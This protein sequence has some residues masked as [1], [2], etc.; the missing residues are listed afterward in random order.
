[1]ASSSNRSGFSSSE[2]VLLMLLSVF[3]CGFLAYSVYDA[4]M[5]A[6]ANLVQRFLMISPL[7]VVIAVHWLMSTRTDPG[8]VIQSGSWGVGLVLVLLCLVISYAPAFNFWS[9]V[10]FQVFICLA[11]LM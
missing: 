5:A 9:C 7:L 3:L 11:L 6:A 4:V 1:M 10:A 8:A 2:Q